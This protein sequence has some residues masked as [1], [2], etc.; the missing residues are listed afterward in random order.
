MTSSETAVRTMPHNTLAEETVLSAI[1]TDPENTIDRCVEKLSPAHFYVR[2]NRIIYETCLAMRERAE[3]VETN[4]VVSRL[5]DAGRLEEVGGIFRV[6]QIATAFVTAA[7]V[8]YYLGLLQEKH[9]L[10]RVIE[11]S[12]R[13][14]QMAHERQDA[15][16]Q[17][18]DEVEKDMLA[19]CESGAKAERDFR[20]ITQEMLANVTKINQLKGKLPGLNWGY[21]DLNKLTFGLK[22][23]EMIVVAARPGIGKTA[24][25][26]NVAEKIAVDEGKP[27]GFMSLEMSAEALALRLACSRAKVNSRSFYYHSVNEG[28]MKEF[29][30]A[31]KAIEGA[32]IHI[33]EAPMISISQLRSSTRRL[34]AKHKIEALFVDYLQLVQPSGLGGRNDSRER[35]VAQVSAGLKSLA[36]ELKIPIVV[37]SQLNR[38]SLKR[39]GGPQLSDLRESGA[40][41]QD[42]DIVCLLSRKD[43]ANDRGEPEK[44]VV[45]EVYVAKNRNGPVGDLKL[46]FFPEFTR[47]E[48]YRESDVNPA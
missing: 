26:L 38:E 47:F 45:A 48:D 15:V 19:L 2:G 11:S 43:A 8:D 33:I 16:E 44:C 46:T 5:K 18:M 22:P 10:R 27:I 34:H 6:N 1:L 35:E 7:N 42:A 24:L 20:E 4:S 25:A 13:F 28:E 21:R 36:V 9:Q 32:P 23:G 29:S 39:D 31:A 40:I 12:T 17:V 14:I 30:Q 41:E 37:L 3:V